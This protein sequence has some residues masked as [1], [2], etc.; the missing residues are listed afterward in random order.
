VVTS[1]RSAEDALCSGKAS[2]ASVLRCSG[3][4][5]PHLE[6]GD[7]DQQLRSLAQ[8]R[9]VDDGQGEGRALVQ[10]QRGAQAD[11]VLQARCL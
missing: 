4:C 10:H 7:L 11:G 6:V 3:S 2:A 8:V 1:V 9:T 5:S